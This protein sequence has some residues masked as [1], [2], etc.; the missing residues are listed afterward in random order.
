MAKTNLH[1][2]QA[3]AKLLGL[4]ATGTEAQLRRRIDNYWKRQAGKHRKRPQTQGQKRPQTKRRKK[5]P[6][7]LQALIGKS[8]T[9]KAGGLKHKIIY[10]KKNNP[11]YPIVTVNENGT[12]YKW[13]VAQIKGFLPATTFKKRSA[14]KKKR[15][16][17]RVI[18][19]AQHPLSR[20]VGSRQ[21]WKTIKPTQKDE[22]REIF[23]YCGPQCF[24]DVN[25]TVPICPKCDG[26]QCYCHPECTALFNAYKKGYDKDTM[27][28]YGKMLQCGW[29][30]AY[31]TGLPALPALPALPVAAAAKKKGENSPRKRAL[32]DLV[33]TVPRLMGIQIITKSMAAL[34]TKTGT[35]TRG[36]VLQTI[37]TSGKSKIADNLSNDE[38][39][40]VIDGI[41]YK[42]VKKIQSTSGKGKTHILYE[43]L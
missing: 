2:L 21:A 7:D 42:N 11:T 5:K 1:K 8:F 37:E 23:S 24:A 18:S 28:R 29:V 32:K 22:L 4:P 30:P 15:K 17:E 33:R 19:A 36:W 38:V 6:V 31:D 10:I 20:K 43:R 34:F 16:R 13:S 14:A 25:H 41:P 12:Q 27:V 26:M 9:A 40:K 39:K 35:G 3:R